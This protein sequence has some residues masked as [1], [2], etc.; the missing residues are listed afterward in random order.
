MIETLA[1]LM[2]IGFIIIYLLIA[3]KAIEARENLNKEIDRLIEELRKSKE[4]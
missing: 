3:W 2:V 4:Q 1:I